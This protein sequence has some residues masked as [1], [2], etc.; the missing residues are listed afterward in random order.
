VDDFQCPV[1]IINRFLDAGLH[2]LAG[3]EELPG[4]V[5][6]Q[7]RARQSTSDMLR[8]SSAKQKGWREA[9]LSQTV[10]N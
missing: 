4:R 9:S 10:G 5:P 6:A 7:R 3:E 2:G 1:R 8:R